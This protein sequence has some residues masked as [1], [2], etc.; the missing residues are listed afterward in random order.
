MSPGRQ[1]RGNSGEA[2][3][4]KQL[5]AFSP[6]QDATAHG[7][8]EPLGELQEKKGDGDE[9]HK[10]EALPEPE[11]SSSSEGSRSA[12]GGADSFG[13]QRDEASSCSE[14]GCQARLEAERQ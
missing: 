1:R 2:A 13:K 4:S 9:P 12:E 14:A 11:A 5:S 3:A 10:P 8:D 7:A 6:P